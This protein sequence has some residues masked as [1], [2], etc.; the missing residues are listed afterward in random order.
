MPVNN[1]LVSRTVVGALR[2]VLVTGIFGTVYL[3][4]QQNARASANTEPAAVTAREDA[5]PCRVG[6]L[7]SIACLAAAWILITFLE[8]RLRL[9]DAAT[10]GSPGRPRGRRFAGLPT[11]VERRSHPSPPT[12]QVLSSD[13]RK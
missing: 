13:A 9:T 1:A 3:V 11:D 4:E 6:W 2:F 7:A 12:L 8:T 10:R 5:R